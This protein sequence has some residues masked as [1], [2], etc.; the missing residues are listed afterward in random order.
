MVS[1][2]QRRTARSSATTGGCVCVA[3][4]VGAWLVPGT[5]AASGVKDERPV[6]L[7][8]YQRP[9][10]KA[11]ET[12][13]Q[14]AS[15]GLAQ[16][17]PFKAGDRIARF[18]SR[19]CGLPMAT[20]E[21]H[22]K[23]EQI[24]LQRNIKAE[25]THEDVLKLR[26]DAALEMPAC[27]AF[28][29][30]IGAV[31]VPQQGGIAKLADDFSFPFDPAI[32]ADVIGRQDVH[33]KLNAAV[34]L[35]L[36]KSS[37]DEFAALSVQLCKDKKSNLSLFLAC[38]VSL[39]IAGANPE[40]KEWPVAGSKIII[41]VAGLSKQADARLD[42]IPVRPEV[43][44]IVFLPTSTS[45]ERLPFDCASEEF[46]ALCKY[47]AAPTIAVD[48]P[49]ASVLKGLSRTS[50]TV[51]RG[52]SSGGFLN[53]LSHFGGGFALN[54][55]PTDATPKPTDVVPKALDAVP[56]PTVRK[57]VVF[58]LRFVIDIDDAS[59]YS[60]CA[61]AESLNPGKWPFDVA[62]F[63]RAVKL[64]DIEHNQQSGKILIADT[65]FDFSGDSG[66][67]PTII[68]TTK[69]IFLRKY[70]HVFDLNE[71]PDPSEDRN[72]DGAYGNGGW[73]GVNLAS[74]RGERSAE[75]KVNFDY[76]GHGLAVT[77]LA[78]GGRQLDAIRRSDRL[79][80]EIGEVNLVPKYD[81]FYISSG[82]IDNTVVFAKSRLNLFDVVNLSLAS[83]EDAVWR[84][85]AV[86]V[87]KRQL[88]FVVAA[89][90]D[91]KLV[92]SS[93]EN[94]VWP[95]ALGGAPLADSPLTTS[96]IT[97]GAHDGNRQWAGFSNYGPGVDILAPG[98]A[99]PTYALKLDPLGNLTGITET[100]LTGT[101]VAAPLVSFAASLLAGNSA[102]QGK[103]AAIK[104]RIQIGS[105]YDAGLQSRTISSGIFN[106]AKVLGFKY[107]IIEVALGQESKV[108][109]L[110]YGT[111]KLSTAD[112]L[113]KCDLGPPI[114]LS[115][116][117]KLARGKDAGDALLVLATDDPT[118]A[119]KLT[120]HFCLPSALSALRIDFTDTETNQTESIESEDFRDYIARSILTP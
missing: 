55:N 52:S 81:N 120:P 9:S 34:S 80:F 26:H 40:L 35:A 85:L 115:S 18:V 58:G 68:A 71:D 29:D 105:D 106:I 30:F 65:G 4:L 90:N 73:A 37:V 109:K 62:E 13:D 33:A 44:H 69:N 103:P 74:P 7:G 77:T 118:K 98:C 95:A 83:D 20:L 70:F 112:G 59:Q 42:R 117:K 8:V 51:A 14:V 72:Q 28:S 84:R 12:I 11:I 114:A 110:R 61:N 46:K 99:V 104:V 38:Q 5:V 76:R 39:T 23:Y 54:F 19:K 64:S 100:S 75:S 93:S 86:D 17:V 24:L 66:T 119:S 6:R 41:P 3:L 101:S 49:L 107:D 78:L 97:V 31:V 113:F 1:I 25:L 10:I 32:F 96:F 88:T 111:A 92:S 94:G 22:P 67:E 15:E 48:R 60:S 57:D 79:K 45:N 102:F 56:K 16:N 47:S 91:G 108:R 2:R 63:E 87:E 43:G 82:F 50:P 116:I 53:S 21:I 89:G 36:I 27:A